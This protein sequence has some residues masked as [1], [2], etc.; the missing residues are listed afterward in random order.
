[1]C[2]VSPADTL[3]MRRSSAALLLLCGIAS[4]L[5]ASAARADPAP[6]SYVGD[7]IGNGA[8]P[9]NYLSVSGSLDRGQNSDSLYLE[10]TIS[11]ASSF[12]IFAGYQRF[13]QEEETTTSSNLDLAYKREFI[14]LPDHEFLCS[15][16]PAIE[17]PLGNR[18]KGS[19]S[20][21]R[22]GVDLLWQKGFD[23]L[24]DSLRLLRPAGLEGDWGWQSKVT[25]VRDDLT[26]ADLELEYS[27]GFLDANIAPTAVPRA[28][29][30]L[31]P[32]LDFDYGQYLDGHRNSPAPEFELTPA[33]AWLDST[34]ELNLG[35]QVA[36]NRASSGTGAV[37][38]V[39]LLG[40]SY[41]QIAPALGRT[42]FQ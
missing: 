36:L 10:K 25:G 34:F 29:R 17:L 15:I 20:H 4:A 39:W 1:M 21:A 31:T 35:V 32:H 14:S 26:S 2:R 18:S 7:F 5:C 16:Y 23:D 28:L 6:R 8:E 40:V 42:L 3:T 30:D 37:A 24:P 19:E 22:A 11:P 27:L 38:F 33:I 41:D 12:S 9:E 13:E